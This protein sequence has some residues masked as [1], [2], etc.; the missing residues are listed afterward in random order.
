MVIVRDTSCTLTALA[1]YSDVFPI[2]QDP[3]VLA[4]VPQPWRRERDDSSSH[5]L[6]GPGSTI[7]SAKV[8]LEGQATSPLRLLLVQI[9]L[10][11][12]A[13]AAFSQAS[14]ESAA[15]EESSAG[16]PI[17]WA[18][19]AVPVAA[20]TSLKEVLR[21][22]LG[23]VGVRCLDVPSTLLESAESNTDAG[24]NQSGRNSRG[25]A[26][27]SSSGSSSGQ[28]SRYGFAEADV[29]ESVL[30]VARTG[31]EGKSASVVGLQAVA[32]SHPSATGIGSGSGGDAAA[33]DGNQDA[34]SL[35]EL[36]EP[37]SLDLTSSVGNHLAMLTS[38]A[39][40]LRISL[41]PTS[42]P[43]W[44]SESAAAANASEEASV[45]TGTTDAAGAAPVFSGNAAASSSSS[46]GG[47]SGGKW[48]PS[49][50][51]E[52]LV[53]FTLPPA[54][55]ASAIA[56]V[57]VFNEDDVGGSAAAAESIVTGGGGASG[58]RRRSRPQPEATGTPSVDADV[59]FRS[60][61][62]TRQR[63]GATPHP[64]AGG[65]STSRLLSPSVAAFAA[66]LSSSFDDVSGSSGTGGTDTGTGSGL[67]QPLGPLS[68]DLSVMS[69][70]DDNGDGDVAGGS[71]IAS[72]G[73]DSSNSGSGSG[74]GMPVPFTPPPKLRPTRSHGASADGVL[75]AAALPYPSVGPSDEGASGA[76]SGSMLNVESPEFTPS[77]STGGNMYR[78]KHDTSAFSAI[79]RHGGQSAAGQPHSAP[80]SSS[81]SSLPLAAGAGSAAATDG[82]TCTGTSKGV[83]PPSP[84]TELE[85]KVTSLCAKVAHGVASL[86]AMV[87]EA[88][89]ELSPPGKGSDVSGSVAIPAASPGAT[90]SDGSIGGGGVVSESPP[91]ASSSDGIAGTS[92]SSIP[93]TPVVSS[94]A[95][96]TRGSAAISDTTASGAGIDMRWLDDRDIFDGP[97]LQAV[98]EM[99]D[100]LRQLGEVGATLCCQQ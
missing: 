22:A 70:V 36:T 45:F 67:T 37:M 39:V 61:F 38:S 28:G 72:G 42:L 65:A 60:P 54:T 53:R 85:A 59:S 12:Q 95:G 74:S 62:P 29:S 24:S 17:V 63:Q 33:G 13:A 47:G 18:T 83:R 48:M 1:T 50:P 80:A 55:P 100:A 20:S 89:A 82:S 32:I 87:E 98:V 11:P 51:W 16:S 8:P 94:L 19:T 92:L 76:A 86:K 6:T 44:L 46:D 2:I 23:S 15:G 81:L 21:R 56:R 35:L 84:G 91:V 9:P 43:P 58:R 41:Q 71:T 49:Q 69:L 97:G 75:N 73:G 25:S 79:H 99:A 78:R 34:A 27:S 26:A 7:V 52:G 93:A 66:G 14:A 5:Q 3:S 31:A 40:A 68:S 88:R 57:M 10:Q 77:F 96:I 90:G 64:A 4:V 30:L